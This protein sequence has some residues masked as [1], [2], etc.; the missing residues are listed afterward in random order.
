M[1][2]TKLLGRFGLSL[3]VFASL[4]TPGLVAQVDPAIRIDH[5]GFLPGETKVA[6]FNQDPGP[7]VRI[8]REDN[9]S[10]VFRIPEDGGSISF[11]GSDPLRSGDTVWWVDFSGFDEAGSYVL[12]SPSRFGTS[13]PFEISHGVYR[14][15]LRTALKSFYFQRCNTPK[16]SAHAGVWADEA[17][18]H[19]GDAQAEAAEG[20]TD[21]GTR[22]HSGGWHDAGDH[23]KYV[24][25][26][27]PDAISPMLWALEA[28]PETFTTLELDIPESGD[29]RPDLLD[30]IRYELDWLLKMQ[31]PSGAVLSRQKQPMYNSS[32]P[33]SAD[34]VT[35]FYR[36]PDFESGAVS[37]GTFAQTARA[38]EFAGEAAYAQTLRSAAIA[39]WNWLQNQSGELEMEVWAAAEILRLDASIQ[40]ARSF[41]ESWDDWS[42]LTFDPDGFAWRAAVAYLKTPGLNQSIKDDMRQSLG[43]TVNAIFDANALYRAG[44]FEW[45]YYWGSNRPRAYY[46][47]FLL[48]S[49][50]VG[51]TGNRDASALREHALDFLH[52]LHGRNPLR[53][54]YLTNMSSVGGEHSSYQM[55]HTWFGD[56]LSNYST[57]R[58]L[59]KPQGIFEEDYPY[60]KGLD[61]LGASD[62]NSSLYGP[63]PGIVPGG[64]NR[65]YGEDRERVSPPAGDLPF[66]RTYRDWADQT[67]QFVEPWQI[68]ENSISYQ[69]PYVGLVARFAPDPLGPIFQDGFERGS[70]AHWSAQAP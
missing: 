10:V 69:G 54:L 9:G 28:S 39:A 6:V 22:D 21:R 26:A 23:N 5:F 56:S 70:V 12:E 24:W 2:P 27:V 43:R 52:Y 45:Q 47:L 38:F 42:T 64:P 55:F 33:P 59:G 8:H 48:E 18:C 68:T 3:L 65:Y 41:V 44:M 1:R 17:V 30:E 32:A 34:Q 36:D 7:S 13:Y 66:D 51:A 53:M 57:A 35:R 60:F 46:G 16:L 50:D 67:N 61:S 63:V 25:R 20:H 49:A 4:A 62:N 29:A 19:T 58:Y 31:L 14:E 11:R 37:A 40:S 15:V